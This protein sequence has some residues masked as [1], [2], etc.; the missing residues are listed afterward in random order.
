MSLNAGSAK[1]QE[2]RASGI[3]DELKLE[4]GLMNKLMKKND[5]AFSDMPFFTPSTYI[6]HDPHHNV[7]VEYQLTF[8]QRL[9][10][11]LEI[12]DSSM[13]AMFCASLVTSCIIIGCVCSS[14]Y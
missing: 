13:M 8:L 12:H 3:M 5:G 7:D 11:M 1:L 2:A 6:Y 14:N 4:Q 10:V 9:F